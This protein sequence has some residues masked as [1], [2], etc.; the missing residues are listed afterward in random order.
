MAAEAVSIAAA[1]RAIGIGMQ[2]DALERGADLL[3][4]GAFGH[5]VVRDFVLGGATE[6]VLEDLRLPILLSH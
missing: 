4:M 2:E 5:S 3:V 1:D 6:D